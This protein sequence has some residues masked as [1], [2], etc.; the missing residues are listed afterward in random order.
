MAIGSVVT[1][2][3]SIAGGMQVSVGKVV[4]RGYAIDQAIVGPFCAVKAQIFMAGVDSSQAFQAGLNKA[5]AFSAGAD[6]SQ[7]GCH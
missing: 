7:A 4:T 5:Q 1:R 3:F 6:K 2:G